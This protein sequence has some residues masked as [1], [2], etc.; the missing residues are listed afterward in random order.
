MTFIDLFSGL[1]G[2][3]LGMEWA[4]HE[5]LG[6]CEISEYAN[7]AYNAVFNPKENEWFE[8]DITKIKPGSIPRADIWTLGFPCQDV[9]IAGK[10]FGLA[11]A[12]SGLFYQVVTLLQAQAEEDKPKLLLI[13]N[14][15]NL[16][17]IHGGWDFARVLLMLDEAG[18]DA[19]W[20]VIDGAWFTPQ[21]RHRIYI[22]GHARGESW[23]PIFPISKPTGSP[24]VRSK[25]GTC[26]LADLP[27]PVWSARRVRKPWHTW[28][29]GSRRFRKPG[30]ASY[31]IV[32]TLRALPGVIVNGKVRVLTPL[33]CLRLQ[34]FPDYVYDRIRFLSDNQIYQLAGNAVNPLVVKAIATRFNDRI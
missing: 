30:Q 16:L 32:A 22:I 11:G 34:G 10:Q 3:R 20:Q 17:S 9:S 15:R 24:T 26:P 5:C 12:R 1:G 28:S 33:E 21:T 14:V 23:K 6:H 29:K 18:Y 31:T 2:F 7:S 25:S 4:G 27:I 8:P 13:E 19:E